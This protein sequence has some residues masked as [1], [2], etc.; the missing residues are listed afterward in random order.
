MQTVTNEYV[1]SMKSPLR[2]RGYLQV[3]VVFANS[4]ATSTA[5]VSSS[6]LASFSQ[7]NSVITEP[8]KDRYTYTVLENDLIPADGT[9]YFPPEN[10]DDKGIDTGITGPDIDTAVTINISFGGETITNVKGF[11]INFG[12]YYATAATA[13]FEYIPSGN[14][15]AYSQLITLKD[16]ASPIWKT[17]V[18]IPEFNSVTIT[19]N[20][21][22]ETGHRVR[23]SAIVFGF[24][25]SFDNE[26]ITDATLTASQSP[27]AETLPQTDFT[28]N[29]IDTEGLFNP[30]STFN[31]NDMLG[32]A[33]ASYVKYGYQ[34][35]SGTIEWLAPYKV[36]LNDWSYTGDEASLTFVDGLRLWSESVSSDDYKTALI[37]LDN[38]NP[39]S[40]EAC[41]GVLQST[42]FFANYTNAMDGFQ[43][44]SSL[45]E[46][47]IS[48]RYVFS[49]YLKECLQKI[50]NAAHSTLAVERDGTIKI[51]PHTDTTSVMTLDETMLLSTPIT[52]VRENV[53][54]L[55]VIWN[56][57]TASIGERNAQLFTTKIESSDVG[58][59][60]VT[61]D[62]W[63]WGN[64]K[65]TIGDTRITTSDT[66]R[67]LDASHWRVSMS[68][69]DTDVGY[70]LT[71]TGFPCDSTEQTY[72]LQTGN[73]RNVLE[74][75][76]PILLS[77]EVESFAKWLWSW[78]KGRTFTYNYRGNPELDCGDIITQQITDT[79][80]ITGI[81]EELTLSFNGAFSGTLKLREV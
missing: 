4:K 81:I 5:V 23:I 39:T 68:I 7:T 53:T 10:A 3:D 80:S 59:L 77:S 60:T 74:W 9:F 78:E 51:Y 19:V 8:V 36:Y 27:V 64:L 37:A 38:S 20:S 62:R 31:L 41:Y 14:E 75:A 50:A 49:G 57:D 76:N 11:Q 40:A 48:K 15:A 24:I 43:I 66:S 71:I 61:F 1:A 42:S 58:T 29:I 18:D 73:Q 55:N 6:A 35:P 34:L 13:A 22:C 44:D 12:K 79:Y 70:T 67:N 32:E 28:M 65:I 30:T 56:K 25:Q 45:S 16:G 69:F 26:V 47:K 54:G 2:E 17:K 63:V 21:L 52:N 33:M 46:Y 72:S